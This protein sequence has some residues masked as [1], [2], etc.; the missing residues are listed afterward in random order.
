MVRLTLQ[1]DLLE[2]LGS[3]ITSGE[4]S[5]QQRLRTDELETEFELSRTVVRETLKVL[6]SMRLVALRRAI[7]ITVLPS[8]EWNVF[9]PRV[10]RWRLTGPGKDQQLRTLTALRVAIEPVAADGAARNATEEQSAELLRLAEW[11][12]SAGRRGSAADIDEFLA[13]DIAYHRLLLQASGNEMFAALADVITEVLNGYAVDARDHSSVP[14]GA[15]PH[16]HVVAAMAI[17]ERMPTRAET[18]MRE[19]LAEVNGLIVGD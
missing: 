10:I 15:G 16:L 11:M 7:G 13:T 14:G 1:G 17:Q 19:I 8:S 18:A 4:Y 5:A 9:D 2:I 6:E 12:E 3:R